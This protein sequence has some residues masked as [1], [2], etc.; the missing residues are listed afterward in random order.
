MV[1][2]CVNVQILVVRLMLALSSVTL[3][4]NVLAALRGSGF[5]ALTL[6]RIRHF[7][8]TKKLRNEALRPLS[9]KTACYR[10]T[11]SFSFGLSVGLVALFHFLFGFVRMVKMKMCY[12]MR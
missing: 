5:L 7:K 8:Y 10:H 3:A 1:C 9:C 4:G 6:K 12:Q 2:P 11:P